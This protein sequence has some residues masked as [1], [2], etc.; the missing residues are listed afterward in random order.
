LPVDSKGLNPASKWG[1]GITRWHA[2][3][4]CLFV[5]SFVCPQLSAVAYR[6]G[7]LL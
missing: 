5:C 3:S 7:Y 6:I 1:R 2:A 4:L